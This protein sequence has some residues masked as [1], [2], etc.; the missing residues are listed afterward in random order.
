MEVPP[1]L[2]ISRRRDHLEAGHLDA[3]HAML[4][5]LRTCLGNSA[6]AAVATAAGEQAVA[7]AVVN[8]LGQVVASNLELGRVLG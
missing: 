6:Q 8:T 7:T 1:G 4:M 2:A 3:S 5:V